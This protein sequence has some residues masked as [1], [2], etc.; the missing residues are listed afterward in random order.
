MSYLL[1]LTW[2][3]LLVFGLVFNPVVGLGVAHAASAT[4]AAAV[5]VAK[6]PPCHGAMAMPAQASQHDAPVPTQDG[7]KGCAHCDFGACCL[8][9]AL[10]LPAPAFLPSQHGSQA[11]HSRELSVAAAPPPSR[12]IRPPIA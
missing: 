8:A 11:A 5:A 9:G 10:D 7:G 1:A 4:P 12:M 2:R 6:A 3:C